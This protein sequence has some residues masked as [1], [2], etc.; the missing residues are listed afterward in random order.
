MVKNALNRKIGDFFS[1]LK[2][3]KHEIVQQTIT[4]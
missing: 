3:T 2:V 4:N 1:T